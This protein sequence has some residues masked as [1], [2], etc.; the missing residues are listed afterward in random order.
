MNWHLIDWVWH[1]RGNLSL[2]V[3]Q[4]NSEI[5]GKIE[6]LFQ[7][8]GTTHE[9]TNDGLVFSKKNQPSQDKMAVFDNGVLSI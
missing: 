4:T 7:E 6:P 3:Q 2:P 5:L 1:V 9:L 8:V